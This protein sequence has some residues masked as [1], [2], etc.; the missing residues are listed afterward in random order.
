MRVDGSRC[1]L[2]TLSEALHVPT[3]VECDKKAQRIRGRKGARTGA[4]IENYWFS[5]LSETTDLIIRKRH[6]SFSCF[7][8]L[9]TT[10]VLLIVSRTISAEGAA[11]E[12]NYR[13]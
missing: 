7:E 5:L 3:T 2:F 8:G 1:I 11:L 13:V 10:L 4:S 6:S 9:G 12:R